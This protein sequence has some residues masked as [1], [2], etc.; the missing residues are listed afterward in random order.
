MLRTHSVR[1]G[2]TPTARRTPWPT[3]G[4]STTEW[5]NEPGRPTAS[6]SEGQGR[7]PA[8]HQGE[9]QAA[10]EHPEIGKERFAVHG[11]RSRAVVP[12]CLGLV[13]TA[14]SRANEPARP[15][16]QK[17]LLDFLQ[18]GRTAGPEQRRGRWNRVIVRAGVAVS[19]K[20]GGIWVAG[21]G[22][23]GQGIRLQRPG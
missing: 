16:Q 7:G 12:G 6:R 4:R 17:T 2:T 13:P 11:L 21:G 1:T 20:N 19:S 8:P 14:G 15:V 22:C 3:P 5:R 9:G 18:T 23:S 10:A